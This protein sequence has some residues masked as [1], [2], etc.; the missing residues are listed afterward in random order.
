M[1]SEK[2]QKKLEEAKT[3]IGDTILVETEKEKYEGILMPRIELG[4]TDC[5]V[6]KLSN[7]YNI[8]VNC[9]KVKRIRLIKKK[10]ETKEEKRERKKETEEDIVILGCGGT[11]ASKVEY[12]TGAVYPSMT[13]EDLVLSFPQLKGEKIRTRILFQL[14]SEDMSPAHWQIIAEEIAKEI[15]KGA[16]GIILLQGT[17]MMH[18]TSAALSFMIK[19]PIPI[20]LVGAQRSGDRG[21]SDN[22]ANLMSAIMLA[23][24]DIAEVGICMHGSINDDFC[25]FHPGVKVR[26]MHTSRRDA[27]QTINRKPIAKVWWEENKIEILSQYKKRN[28]VSLEVDTKINPNVALIYTY[29][30]I[31]SKFIE[32]LSDFDGVVIAATGLGHVPSNILNDPRSESIIPSLKNLI[33]RNISVVIAPQTIFGRINT[34][35]YAAGRKLSEIGVIG[36]YCDWTPETALVKL[37]FVLGHTKDMKKIKEFM[38]TNIAGEISERS[39]IYG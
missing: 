25:Y 9:D 39:E 11:I 34:N 30:G 33:E 3:S 13:P 38:L 7:G 18:Y 14:L 2:V 12:K 32:K 35:V 22:L 23:K 31:K 26:K 4:D 19:A 21:S 16:R 5:I 24:S 17:D 8:G 28:S 6:I 29:P 37:M 15:K 20:V 36:N 1:Y 10:R 27:F